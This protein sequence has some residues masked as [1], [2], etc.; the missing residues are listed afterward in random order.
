MA[1]RQKAGDLVA[2]LAAEA[3]AALRRRQGSDQTGPDWIN[4]ESVEDGD[5]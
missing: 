5:S 2:R 4:D 1:R 3:E